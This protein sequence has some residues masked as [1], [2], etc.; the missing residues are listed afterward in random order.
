MIKKIDINLA[1]RRHEESRLPDILTGAALLLA[2]L[3]SWHSADTYLANRRL[4][5]LKNE[6]F[7]AM[8]AKLGVTAGAVTAGAVTA[9]GIKEIKKEVEFVNGIIVRESFS[10]TD[11]LTRLEATVPPNISIIRISPDFSGGT[12]KLSGA[13]KSMDDIFKFVAM[14]GESERFSDVFLLKHSEGGKEGRRR[15]KSGKAVLFDIS[16]GYGGEA[17]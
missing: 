7:A 4:L 10:W 14:L 11:L 12:V 15:V 8:E 3:Y 16:A 17:L 6:T 1:T 2:L 9:S 13:G 5:S